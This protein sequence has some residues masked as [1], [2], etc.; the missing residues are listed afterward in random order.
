MYF[1]KTL[2]IFVYLK[3]FHNILIT[4]TEKHQPV[5]Q[6]HTEGLIH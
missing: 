3:E 4:D 5:T 1:F 2:L 6:L